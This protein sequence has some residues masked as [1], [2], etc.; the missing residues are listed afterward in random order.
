MSN[1]D[2]LRRFLSSCPDL[3]RKCWLPVAGGGGGGGGGGG[4]F[5]TKFGGNKPFRPSNFKW[6][7]CEECH[8]HKSFLCQVNLEEIPKEVQEH[9][10]LSSGLFQLFFCLECMPLN[11]FKDIFFIRKTEFV[12][13]LS[14][15]AAEEV[16]KAASFSC[17]QLPLSLQHFVLDSTET[18]DIEFDGETFQERLVVSWREG[19]RPEIP[20]AQEIQALHHGQMEQLS[21]LSSEELARLYEDLEELGESRAG[22][23]ADWD[24]QTTRS[25]ERFTTC[26]YASSVML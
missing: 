6:P 25:V 22:C 11:C 18:P 17:D 26:C 24:T 10:G 23:E 1:D 5:Q 9:I 16:V 19:E 8:A 20:Q 21:R 15:L 3:P 7:I 12:P 4:K 2:L 13:S 14:S